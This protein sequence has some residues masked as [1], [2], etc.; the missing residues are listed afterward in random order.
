LRQIIKDN[1]EDGWRRSILDPERQEW[2]FTPDEVGRVTAAT[3]PD[4]ETTYLGY[5]DRGE[6]ESVTPPGR[7]A[8]EFAFDDYGH[9]TGYFAPSLEGYPEPEQEIAYTYRLDHQLD[10][11]TVGGEAIDFNYSPNGRLSKM[12]WPLDVATVTTTVSYDAAGRPYRVSAL[13]ETIEMT[14]DGSLPLSMTRMGTVDATV[15]W[16]YDRLLRVSSLTAAGTTVAYTYNDDDQLTSIGSMTLDHDPTTG[17]LTGTTLG[18]VTTALTF[19]DFGQLATSDAA[20][21]SV[22]LFA[23]DFNPIDPTTSEQ[24][25]PDRLGRITAVEETIEGE[26]VLRHIGDHLGASLQIPRFVTP[27]KAG[28]QNIRESQTFWIPACAGMTKKRRLAGASSLH[29]ATS[30]P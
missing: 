27:A 26:S 2:R 6:L 14:Y 10:T 7:D 30:R 9:T 24:L 17:F 29:Q 22:V 18:G 20:I 16:A 19:D 11:V 12:T 28:V 5:G 25:G 8:H 15:T 23:E 13:G 3:R 21:G 4:D 1:A